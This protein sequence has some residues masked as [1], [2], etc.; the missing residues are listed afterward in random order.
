MKILKEH[1]PQFFSGTAS[2]LLVAIGGTVLLSVEDRTV[3]AVLFTVA[4]LSICL[5]DLYLYTGKIG[6]VTESFSKKTV[7]ELSFGLFG[8]FLGATLTG[9]IMRYARPTLIEKAAQSCTAKLSEGILRAFVLGC[10]CGM[11]MYAA[12]KIYREKGSVWGIVFCIPV[13]I[14][15]GFEHSIADMFYFAIAGMIN[16][17]YVGFI[18]AVV[19]GNS[20]GA[21]LL[22][23]LWRLKRGGRNSE[24]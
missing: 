5:M 13:F 18:V 15:S 6:F 2:G 23:A 12:V 21:V 3:G 11:L 4:L 14:L 20:I 19:F 9:L 7:A 24:K 8:N 10:F 17:E 16:A 22:A 1:Y